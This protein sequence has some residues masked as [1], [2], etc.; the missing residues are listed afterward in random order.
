MYIDFY[1][2]TNMES[3]YF[4]KYFILMCFY[5]NVCLIFLN[6]KFI[7]FKS[8]ISFILFLLSNNYEIIIMY[9]ILTKL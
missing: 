6:K 2:N 1:F 4:E 9:T 5:Y 7:N 3:T 8:L